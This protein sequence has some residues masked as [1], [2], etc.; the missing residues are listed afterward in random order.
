MLRSGLTFFFCTDCIGE[1]DSRFILRQKCPA[2]FRVHVEQTNR[3]CDRPMT[4]SDTD[5][6]TL[7][8]SRLTDIR[9]HFGD[10]LETAGRLQP[11]G[12]RLQ[13]IDKSR[14][15][16]EQDVGMEVMEPLGR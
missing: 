8:K 2:S 7:I 6:L 15:A 3:T 16:P 4:R 13:A 5:D 1:R 12:V 10:T 9:Y 14:P 11:I